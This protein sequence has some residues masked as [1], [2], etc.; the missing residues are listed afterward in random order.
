MKYAI[1]YDSHSGNTAHVAQTIRDTL[2]QEE[3]LCV[4][5]TLEALKH[6]ETFADAD[7]IFYG[8]WTDRLSCPEQSQKLMPQLPA[9]KIALFAT[10]GFGEGQEYFQK[11]MDNAAQYLPQGATLLDTFTCTGK[12]PMSVQEQYIKLLHDPVIGEQ[13]KTMLQNYDLVKGH[14]DKADLEAA[15]A[16]AKKQYDAV[17]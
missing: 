15:A 10:A 16:F 2:P 12:M 11:I 17:K 8:F 14:P 9:T 13:A 4:Y 5:S 3:C 1:L 7:L 6:P